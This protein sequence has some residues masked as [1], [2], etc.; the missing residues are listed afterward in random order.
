MSQTWE[1][2][3]D[4]HEQELIQRLADAVAIPSV[5][6]EPARR[7]DCRRMVDWTQ[8]LLESLQVKVKRVE[9]GPQKQSDGSEIPLPDVLFGEIGN[10]PKKKTILLYGHIDVQPAEVPHLCC[11]RR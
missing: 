2:Y 11:C 7:P 8:Q 6:G 4:A 9:L 3:V 1:S 10:D 5:S